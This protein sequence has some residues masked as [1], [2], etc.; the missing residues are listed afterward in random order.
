MAFDQNL[1][2]YQPKVGDFAASAAEAVILEENDVELDSAAA[3]EAFHKNV[4]ESVAD[5]LKESGI[6]PD[7]FQQM[8]L[9]KSLNEL[10][11]GLDE[12]KEKIENGGELSELDNNYIQEMYEA[13]LSA[14]DNIIE[15]NE[16]VPFDLNEYVHEQFADNL[17]VSASKKSAVYTLLREYNR[18]VK[19]GGKSEIDQLVEEILDVVDELVGTV[20][21][22]ELHGVSSDRKPGARLFLQQLD[23]IGP[24]SIKFNYKTSHDTNLNAQTLANSEVATDSKETWGVADHLRQ[25]IDTEPSLAEAH[26]TADSTTNEKKSQPL[27]VVDQTLKETKPDEVLSVAKQLEVNSSEYKVA[28]NQP[29]VSKKTSAH[30]KVDPTKQKETNVFIAAKFTPKAMKAMKAKKVTDK[31]P[32]ENVLSK[33]AHDIKKAVAQIENLPTGAWW[34]TAF[35]Q[36]QSPYAELGDQEFDSLVQNSELDYVTVAQ[37]AVFMED[38]RESKNIEQSA[39]IAWMDLRPEITERRIKTTGQTLKQVAD[40]LMIAREEEGNTQST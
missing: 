2:E 12:I 36:G 18:A 10:S 14:L 6:E 31:S 29:V 5:Q 16:E 22:A 40:A 1:E 20:V 13:V 3:V 39:Y 17:A 35:N 11:G 21:L 7:Q 33:T 26:Q 37:R 9:S 8:S 25:M 32:A 15:S 28:V 23:S 30:Y 34:T 19:D 24:A 27:V 4:I 38:L